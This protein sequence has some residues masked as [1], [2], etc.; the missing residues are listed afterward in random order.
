MLVRITDQEHFSIQRKHMKNFTRSGTC[1]KSM[2]EIGAAVRRER[3]R[4]GVTQAELA[5]SAGTGL[6]FVVDLEMGKATL[7]T[8]KLLDVL[9]ALGLRLELHARGEDA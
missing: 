3:K 2:Q 5:M 4:L 7:Q 1:M 8:G 6:R 9:Q